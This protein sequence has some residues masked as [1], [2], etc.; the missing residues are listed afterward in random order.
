VVFGIVQR[1]GPVKVWHVKSTGVRVLRPLIEQNVVYGNIVHTDGHTAYKSL[2][3]TGYEHRWTDHGRG[4]YYTPDSYT[5]NIE[6]VWSHFKRGIK[7]VYRHIGT[8]Y[9]QAYANEYAW[10]YSNRNKPMMF[11]S[12]LC[13]ISQNI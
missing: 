1:G 6:N 9:I 2:R 12:L 11:F 13:K 7:G 4:Q 5:Q 10:R 3:K 8:D